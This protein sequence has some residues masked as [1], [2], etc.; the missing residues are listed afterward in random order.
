MGCHVVFSKSAQENKLEKLVRLGLRVILSADVV[1]AWRNRA[2]ISRADIVWTHTESQYLAVAMVGVLL[3]KRIPMIGQTVWLMDSWDRLTAPKKALIRWLL[4]RVDVL[5]FHSPE[6]LA[7][8]KV[9]FPDAKVRLVKF[10]IPAERMHAPVAQPAGSVVNILALGNDRHRDWKTLIEAVSG[11]PNFRLKILSGSVPKRLAKRGGNIEVT[12]ARSNDELHRA[13]S[14]ATV[15][16]VAL[17]DN[18]HASG[19][20]VIQEAILYGVPVVATNIG[21][22]SAY[23]SANEI[24]YVPTGDAKALR[25]AFDEIARDPAGALKR[26]QRAQALMADPDELGAQAYIRDHVALSR[27][28]LGR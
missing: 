6:N 21:G 5:T 19:L 2:A 20:T 12:R 17:K 13:F 10:G 15:V 28:I 25:A 4:S 8:A 22:L 14:E 16:C 26:A 1:H 3:G 9:L 27:E 18:L 24:R 11:V 23:F 7:R